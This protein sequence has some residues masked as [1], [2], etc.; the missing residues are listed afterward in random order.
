MKSKPF[1]QAFRQRITNLSLKYKIQLI[2]LT[3]L[4]LLSLSSLFIIQLLLKDYNKLLSQS[5]KSSLSYANEDITETLTNVQDLSYTILSDSSMQ[6]KLSELKSV[7]SPTQKSASYTQ[8]NSLLQSYYLD[9]RKNHVS[10]ITVYTDKAVFCTDY[11]TA[12]ALPEQAVES[13][14]EKAKEQ[15]GSAL[16]ITDYTQD[17]KL[18]LTREIRR[19]E[20]LKLDTLGVMVICINLEDL[21]D[22][23]S[24]FSEYDTVHYLLTDDNNRILYNSITSPGPELASLPDI[25]DNGYHIMKMNRH[26]YFA[27]TGTLYPEEHWN[28]ICLVSY[29]KIHNTLRDSNLLGMVL[30]LISILLIIYLSSHIIKSLTIHFDYLMLKMKYFGQSEQSIIDYDYDC[31]YDYRDRND[32]AGKLHKQFD[33]MA[34]QISQ[35][36]TTNYTYELLIKETQ[37]KALEMQINPHFL[38]NTL[39]TINWRAKAIGETRISTMA[40]SLGNL[41]RA[42]LRD[43]KETF[44]LRQ[45]LE[46]VQYYL[47]IQKCRFDT[48]LLYEIHVNPSHLELMIPKL[49]IQ[50]LVENSISHAME[51]L[52]DECRI[53][54]SAKVETPYLFIYVK[55][56]GSKF[57]TDLLHKLQSKTITPKGMGIGLLNINQRIQLQFGTPYGV[58]L[59]NENKWAVAQLCLPYREQERN[60][61]NAKTCD[62]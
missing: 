9:Y 20:N 15:H 3:C 47:N 32:E 33:H 37:L 25:A 21:L 49:I 56:S 1:I 52:I 44:T 60:D 22:S 34:E 27:V 10:Y 39:E 5:V 19:Y 18:I 29:D 41:F 28:Y 38:Y 6:S 16:W 13:I 50:P 48:R 54:I 46:L 17:D 55:N 62:C 11:K 31:P 26:W 36:I 23:R 57:E 24:I 8:I 51:N 42:V 40:E 4:L 58:T 53:I 61:T 59:Y 7:T 35:L 45:E 2:S 14:L 43:P 12:S 30:I